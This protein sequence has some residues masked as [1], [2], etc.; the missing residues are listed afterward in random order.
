[1]SFDRLARSCVV[2]Y[3]KSRSASP[4]ETASNSPT[5]IDDHRYESIDVFPRLCLQERVAWSLEPEEE[6]VEGELVP[7]KYFVESEV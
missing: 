4:R 1:M 6:V 3:T 2:I 5:N 7:L